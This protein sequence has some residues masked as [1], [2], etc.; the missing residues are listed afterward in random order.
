MRWRLL[1]IYTR[2]IVHATFIEKHEGRKVVEIDIRRSNKRMKLLSCSSDTWIS[3]KGERF[4]GA[5]MMLS[6]YSAI[7]LVL[8]A[9]W[10]TGSSLLTPCS[11]WDLSHANHFCHCHNER[12]VS[13]YL[14]PRIWM[15]TQYDSSR[16]KSV[17]A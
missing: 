17:L 9:D 14:R 12:K 4:V 16:K 7:V 10:H 3:H 13:M 2:V 5:N 11:I 6:Y 8:T 1:S 15:P